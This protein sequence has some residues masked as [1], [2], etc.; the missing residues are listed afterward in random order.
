MHE[1]SIMSQMVEGILEEAG[2]HDATK[3]EEVVLDLGDFTMLGDEQLKFAYEVLSKGTILEGSVL[4]IR[5]IKGRIVCTCGFQGDMSPS[6]DAPHRAVPI[7]E[8]PKCKGA[9]E[10]V[11]GRECVVRNIRLVVPDV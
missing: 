2:R 5:H 6:E 10:I 11:E 8:C 9:A 7:L 3:V 4:T 1:F